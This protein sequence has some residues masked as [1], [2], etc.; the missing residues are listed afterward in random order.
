MAS[1]VNIAKLGLKNERK[2]LGFLVRKAEAA[3]RFEDMCYF[4]S[5]LIKVTK[6]ELN[7]EERSLFST[8]HKNIIGAKRAGWRT[9]LGDPHYPKLTEMYRKQVCSLSQ[10]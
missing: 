6:G 9:L 8:A 7:S 4:M 1:I 10:P 3:E 5:E 2:E